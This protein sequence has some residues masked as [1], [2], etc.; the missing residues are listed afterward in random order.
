MNGFFCCQRPGSAASLTA[1]QHLVWG[2]KQ[3]RPSVFLARCSSVS[4]D[5]YFGLLKFMMEKSFSHLSAFPQV[6]LYVL[7]STNLWSWYW[8]TSH[9]WMN[10]Y[11]HPW[12]P[13]NTLSPG[14]SEMHSATI[15]LKLLN[16]PFFPGQTILEACNMHFFIKLMTRFSPF[17]PWYFAYS[18]ACLVQ[19]KTLKP[20]Q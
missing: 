12:V 6:A 13:G 16:W 19:I 11:P 18:S 9:R 20:S 7:K 1:E 8:H 3:L 4:L 17:S 14:R 5:L 10:V 15:W 2:R